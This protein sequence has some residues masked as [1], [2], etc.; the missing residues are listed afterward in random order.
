MWIVKFLYRKPTQCGPQSL[1]REL[2][3]NI[4]CHWNPETFYSIRMSCIVK[5]FQNIIQN[6]SIFSTKFMHPV[7]QLVGEYLYSYCTVENISPTI[8]YLWKNQ[9]NNVKK[10]QCNAV[11]A[12]NVD[13]T[14]VSNSN[15]KMTMM[16]MKVKF[17]GKETM[18]R[19]MASV[20]NCLGDNLEIK[21]SLLWQWK[22]EWQ[23]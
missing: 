14:N 2:K 6:I 13:S 22:R 21:E 23:W 9:D 3:I 15:G 7:V 4:W 16:P 17:W 1:L 20:M 8:N 19:T 18:E 5:S 11:T 12:D 10:N